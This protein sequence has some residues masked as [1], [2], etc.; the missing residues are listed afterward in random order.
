M[1]A[2]NDWL[3]QGLEKKYQLVIKTM[4]PYVEA[5]RAKFG[6]GADTPVGKWYDDVFIP[7]GYLPFTK[8]YADW[9][10]PARRTPVAVTRMRSAEKAAGPLFRELYR[11]LKANPGVTN[12]DLTA[13]GLPER[14]D[15]HR[16][17]APV[18]DTV[19]EFGIV[20][21]TG[22]RIM[23]DYY[24]QGTTHKKGKPKG[25]HGVEIRWALREEPVDDTDLLTN[26]AFDTASP[27]VLTFQ[28]HDHGRTLYMALRWENTRGEK[29]PWSH[30]AS[31]TV[32]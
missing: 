23:I 16:K 24:P 14:T 29:G 21:L 27:A 3:P 22:H 1:S 10:D 11:V 20:P 28:G 7:A 15:P 5:N 17:P 6:M 4:S 13:M 25:Q 31:T 2:K 8:A 30:I 26:S 32:P 18:A 19:P 12:D 9:S